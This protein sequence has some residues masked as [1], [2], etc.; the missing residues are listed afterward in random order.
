M[1]SCKHMNIII[2]E[3]E[4]ERNRYYQCWIN[5]LQIKAWYLF[6][7]EMNAKH[8]GGGVAELIIFGIKIV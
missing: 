1:I 3:I 7:L 8:S 4:W 5:L 2:L 6:Y